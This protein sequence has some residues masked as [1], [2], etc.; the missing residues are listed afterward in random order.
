M[1]IGVM[2]FFGMVAAIVAASIAVRHWMRR[3]RFNVELLIIPA[4]ADAK[5]STEVKRI[6]ELRDAGCSDKLSYQGELPKHILQIRLQNIGNRTAVDVRGAIGMKYPLDPV[7][8]L[9]SDIDIEGNEIKSVGDPSGIGAHHQIAI[10]DYG[11]KLGPSRMADKTYH[12]PI[13]IHSSPVGEH[14]ISY[15]FENSEGYNSNG[16]RE[17]DLSRGENKARIV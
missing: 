4:E 9:L 3:P 15:S 16:R 11:E 6:Q 5:I 14:Y 13:F 1:L 2:T 8:K 12:I 17:V 7:K 10:G